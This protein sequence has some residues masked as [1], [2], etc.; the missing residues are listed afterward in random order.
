MSISSPLVSIVIPV[1]N[2]SN[3]LK[4]AIDS[5]L[6]QTYKNIEILVIND[7]SN[8]GDLTH[9]LA[10]SFGHKINYYK[11]VN[12]G[13]ASALNF[14]ISKMQGEYFSWLSHDDIYKSDKIEKQI[15]FVNNNKEIKIVGGNFESFAFNDST[16]EFNIKKDFIFKNA[17]DVLNNWLFFCTM[18]I[19]KDCLFTEIFN[20]KNSDCQDLEAQLYLIKY[21]RFHIVNEIVMTQRVH[22]ESGT[23]KNFKLHHKRKNSYY[24]SLLEKYKIDFFKENKNENDYQTLAKLGDICMKN[25]LNVAG[26]FYFRKAFR[27][28]PKSLKVLL[29][30]LLGMRIWRLI[31]EN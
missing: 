25:S 17:Y 22:K 13:V 18:L 9:E 2:G 16:T 20:L 30:G 8:D 29:F 12:E 31:Y 3:Y 27:N 19:H 21:H 10:L 28:K 5:A 4:E 23:H 15:S 1:Y 11:K 26:K 7:G 6:A 24:I 14:G